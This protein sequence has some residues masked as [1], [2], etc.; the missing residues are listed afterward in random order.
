MTK[1][2]ISHYIDYLIE[3]EEILHFKD[4]ASHKGSLLRGYLKPECKPFREMFQQKLKEFKIKYYYKDTLNRF[5]L[6]K[7]LNIILEKE[8]KC[9]NI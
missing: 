6:Y 9:K 4:K 2:K 3:K 8:N 5:S 1:P 7:V